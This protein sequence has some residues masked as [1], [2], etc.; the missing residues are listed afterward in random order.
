MIRVIYLLILPIFLSACL[1]KGC[2]TSKKE[3]EG[4]AKVMSYYMGYACGD[5]YAQYKIK[6][7]LVSKQIEGAELLEKDL[8]VVLKS[9]EEEKKLDSLVS[10]CA[11]CYD[12][13][14]EGDVFKREVDSFYT[15][16][17]NSYS[18]R[19]RDSTCC[20]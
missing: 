2:K 14:F 7:V 20:N 15:M 18:V 1:A 11:I 13:Y 19:L 9:S 12:F 5:C 8:K 16:K 17:V 10:K 4:T 6:Q 3:W